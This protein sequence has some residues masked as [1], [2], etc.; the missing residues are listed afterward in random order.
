MLKKEADDNLGVKTQKLGQTAKRV[1][2]NSVEL[3]LTPKSN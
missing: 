3:Y 2:P 1:P